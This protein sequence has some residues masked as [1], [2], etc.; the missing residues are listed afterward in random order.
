MITSC[1]DSRTSPRHSVLENRARLEWCEGSEVYRAA[2]RLVNLCEGGALLITEGMPPLDHPVWCRLE[3][4]T[5]TDWIRAKV[6][7]H[8]GDREVG[9][10]FPTSCPYDFGLAATLGLNFDSLFGA[11]K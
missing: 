6:V 3:E 8:G 4:P 10:S 11:A 7:R 1:R 5:P 2:A 9:L